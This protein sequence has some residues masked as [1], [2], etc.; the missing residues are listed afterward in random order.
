M[1]CLNCGATVQGRYCHLC[2]QENVEPKETFWHMVIHF[3]YDMTHFDSSFFHTVHHL[4]LKPGFLSK[5]YT[6]GRRAS[7][8]H[9]IRMYVFSSAIFFLLFFSLF[10]PGES[11]KTNMNNPLP[12]KERDAFIARLQEKLRKDTGNNLL[13]QELLQ[14]KD[15]SQ[16]ITIKDV[17]GLEEDYEFISFSGERF[18]RTEEYDSIQQSLPRYERDGW[19]LRRLIKKEIDLNNRYREDP[20]GMMDKFGESILH[21][22]PYM[23]FISLP[24]FALILKLIYIRRKQFYFADHGIFTIHLYIFSFILLMVVFGLDKLSDL[25]GWGFMGI[26]EGILF[27]ALFFYLYKAMRN[28]YGQRRGKTFLKFL[29]VAFLSLLMMLVLFVFFMFFSAVTF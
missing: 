5:E 28:F 27:L 4:I 29:I 6:K 20:E 7:Y 22:L 1:N 26:V 19:I 16:V 14:A 9:P 21:R 8:L 11:I 23:L 3:F 25:P 10:K 12:A 15:T 13:K 17:L 2:G 18:K 24:L